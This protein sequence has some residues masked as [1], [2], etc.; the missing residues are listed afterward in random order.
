MKELGVIACSQKMSRRVLRMRS[1]LRSRATELRT[2]HVKDSSCKCQHGRYPAS[3]EGVSARDGS[4][5]MV[6]TRTVVPSV[7]PGESK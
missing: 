3:E 4:F 7:T 6:Q 5:A 2:T 1:I